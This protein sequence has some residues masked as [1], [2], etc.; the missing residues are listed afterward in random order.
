M[1]QTLCCLGESTA[2]KAGF[3]RATS[4]WLRHRRTNS[5]GENFKGWAWIFLPSAISRI[6]D[7]NWPPN[8]WRAVAAWSLQV[9]RVGGMVIPRSCALSATNDSG[10]IG[11]AKSAITASYFARSA[12]KPTKFDRSIGLLQLPRVETAVAPSWS[13]LPS[14]MNWSSWR[15]SKRNCWSSR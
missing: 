11:N 6:S 15:L 3:W 9:L 8:L 14:R 12:S 2:L 13:I 4:P 10:G 7:R 5:T 1:Q